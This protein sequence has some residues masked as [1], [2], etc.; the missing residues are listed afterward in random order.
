MR[1][2]LAVFVVSL[3]SFG[4]AQ[5]QC[6]GTFNQT[7]TG[8]SGASLTIGAGQRVRIASG[9]SQ[10]GAINSMGAGS[11]LCIDAGAAINAPVY[12]SNGLIRN[13][14]SA[15]VISGIGLNAGGSVINSATMTFNG[16]F[17]IS[18]VVSIS[19]Q[20]SARL[21]V[22]PYIGLTA[23]STLTNEGSLTFGN[24]FAL[25]NGATF[26]NNNRTEIATSWQPAGTVN[27][28]GFIN[29]LGQIN[30]D[31][32]G[33]VN[34]TCW[35]YTQG[36]FYNS[37]TI[38]NSGAI[39]AFGTGAWQNNGSLQGTTTSWVVGVN[40]QNGGSGVSGY[41]T[42]RFSG[43]TN[44]YAAF[45]GSSAATPILFYDTT[46]TGSQIMD[47]QSPPPTNTV[48]PAADPGAVDPASFTPVPCAEP[49]TETL[50]RA[51]LTLTINNGVAT[52]IAGQT[53]TYS[54]T[55]AN[56]GPSSA[57]G[58]IVTDPP[59]PGL[60]CTEADCEVTGGGASCPASV[61]PSSLAGGQTITSLP[62][63]SSLTFLLTCDVTA[64]G[65]P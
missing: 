62:A 33:T 59:V 20:A 43:T 2:R 54:I 38:V 26:T 45:A 28:N 13:F 31:T 7:V 27:N 61:T 60:T 65:F 56:L 32:T 18:G 40:F 16:Y 3:L 46:Q 15:S 14:G 1:W 51:T 22:N 39:R 4:S 53:T 49:Y 17:S 55:I 6:T 11:E 25:V 63:A 48:R 36:T 21:V 10:T 42:Y 12:G 29:G 23:G 19:N 34:N 9:A 58:T 35:L 47:A 52:L 57:N 41:G 64:T 8:A 5:A 44:N 50:Q 24:Q 30:V 37:G